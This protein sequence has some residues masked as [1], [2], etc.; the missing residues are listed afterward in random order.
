M[1]MPALRHTPPIGGVVGQDVAFDHSDA[2]VEVRKYPRGEHPAH[3]C[4]ENNRVL[5]ELRH[6]HS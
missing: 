4:A 3:T 5:T 2:L 1:S 6:R